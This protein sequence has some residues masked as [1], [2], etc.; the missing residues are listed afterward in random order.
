MALF[1]R[2]EAS[3]S[4]GLPTGGRRDPTRV[5]FLDDDAERATVFLATCPQAVWVQ[6]AADCMT[7]LDEPWD[8]V[9]LDHDLGGEQF[10]DI[11]RD[12]C[13][14]EVV[15]WIC[16][17]PRSHLRSTRF[18]IHSH[19]PVAATVMGVQ[20]AVSGFNCEVRPFGT[21]TQD[22]AEADIDPTI[23]LTPWAKIRRGVR[24][25]LGLQDE[26]DPAFY[27][28]LAQ[29]PGPDDPAPERPDFNWSSPAA[30]MP[31]PT[32]EGQEAG[33]AS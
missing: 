8:E 25:L 13:G 15:R 7:R 31:K 4:D 21:S 20:M 1:Q 30:G 27:D 19:N 33:P 29:R 24:R 28:Y 16:L 12:D 3:G 9:H 2:R 32:S 14:M 10:V 5:L 11:N 6:T 18:F 26:I 22:S 17:T 23:P